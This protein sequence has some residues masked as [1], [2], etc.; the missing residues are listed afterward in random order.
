MAIFSDFI[1]ESLEVFMDDFTVFRPSFDACLDHLTRILDV[2]VKKRLVLSWDK[3]HFMV[4][5]GSL[6]I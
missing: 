4:R 5:E 2:C 1:G 6:G 3:S